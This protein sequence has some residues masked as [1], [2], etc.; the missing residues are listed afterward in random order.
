[1][2]YTVA[3]LA[4]GTHW[5]VAVMQAFCPYRGKVLA[6]VRTR[7]NLYPHERFLLTAGTTSHT[8]KPGNTKILKTTIPQS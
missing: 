4:Q 8:R 2:T 6:L 7:T 5:A 3:I 1:M